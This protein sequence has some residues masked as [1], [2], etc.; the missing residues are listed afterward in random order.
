[1][2]TTDAKRL[3]T[4]VLASLPQPHGCDVMD[5][6]YYEIEQRVDWKKRYAGLCE[7]LGKAAA[8]NWCGF[9]IANLEDRRCGEQVPT[10]RSRLIATYSKLTEKAEAPGKKVKEA[11]A[12]E[13]MAAYFQEHR[14]KLPPAIRRHRE[15]IVELLMAGFSA[16]D[17]FS[18]VVANGA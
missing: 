18:T 2:R 15:T 5:D 4:D 8:K 17:A 16:E 7:E 9:W 14:S 6:V 12:V 1:M 3:M 11:D 13:S 10:T